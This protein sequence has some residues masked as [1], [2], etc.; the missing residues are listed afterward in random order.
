MSLRRKTSELKGLIYWLTKPLPDF[1]RLGDRLDRAGKTITPKQYVL[2][3]VLIRCSSSCSSSA[4][5]FK[6]SL[7]LGLSLGIILGVWL[8]L[9]W[10]QHIFDQQAD[11][12][13]LL[14]FP[15]AIDLIVRGLR[16]GLPVSESLVL[17]SHEVPDP[18]GAMFAN[19]S[20]TMKLGVTLEKALQETARKLDMTEF[21]FFVTGKANG[22]GVALVE[23]YDLDQRATPTLDN[24]STRGDVLTNDNV[25]IG[26]F[27]IGGTSP[28][29]VLIRGIGPD[30][31][32]YGVNGVLSDPTLTLYD[33]Q[34]NPPQLIAQND[35]WQTTQ[36]GEIIA[37]DQVAA[38]IA[39][40]KMPGDG[41]DS[42][43]I[44]TLAPGAYTAILQGK[45]GAVGVAL[46]KFTN[47]RRFPSEG[48]AV[49]NL[50]LYRSHS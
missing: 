18:V 30:L 31:A 41:H 40:G 13:F 6:K 32:Q 8:P 10:L 50:A 11:K 14:L 17:V 20:N 29:K 5:I 42:A 47:C 21:N 37:A 25:M 46:V 48:A 43:I 7:L 16:S 39:T 34:T 22:T 19:I 4:F 1:K 44:A 9:K 15:D 24:I 23:V 12:A 38:I 36:L 2:R 35:D 26:G 3:R 27:I 28:K 33:Q 45:N 49:Q